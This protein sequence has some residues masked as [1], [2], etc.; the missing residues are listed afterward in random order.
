MKSIIGYILNNFI[1]SYHNIIVGNPKIH[2]YQNF[3]NEFIL[4]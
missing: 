3:K 4:K 2:N 1:Y